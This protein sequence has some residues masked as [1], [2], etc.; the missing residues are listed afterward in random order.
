[1]T[2]EQ[3]KRKL[4]VD[5]SWWEESCYDEAMIILDKYLDEFENQNIINR[6][7]VIG[8][9]QRDFVKL[10]ENGHYEISMQDNGKTIKLFEKEYTYSDES[11]T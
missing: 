4:N 9:E 3:L 7:E 11:T 2:R 10:L 6:V 1:M 8:K 5:V